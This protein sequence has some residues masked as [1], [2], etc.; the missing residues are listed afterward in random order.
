MSPEVCAWPRVKLLQM[1]C[2]LS[3]RALARRWPEK[4]I[5]TASCVICGL[6]AFACSTCCLG[7]R[8]HA[9][10]PFCYRL[11]LPTPALLCVASGLPFVGKVD[12]QLLEAV[13]FTDYLRQRGLRSDLS[14][15]VLGPL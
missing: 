2:A 8:L 7:V 5:V 6:L 13:G 4:K 11:T 15:A 14:A 10:A 12:M 3:F 9:R 1:L